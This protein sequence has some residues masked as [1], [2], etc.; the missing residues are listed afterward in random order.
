[1]KRIVA[2]LII[3]I[4]V[5]SIAMADQRLATAT[6]AIVRPADA[7]ADDQPVASCVAERLTAATALKPVADGEADITLTIHDASIGKRPIARL[8]VTAQDGTVIWEGRSKRRLNMLDRNMSCIL[9]DDLL[10]DLREARRKTRDGVK[11]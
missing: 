10:S 8:T 6:R 3:I 2:V 9:T 5:S 11:R 7:L 4:S 1:M